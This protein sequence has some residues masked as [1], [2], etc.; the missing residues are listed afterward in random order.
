MAFCRNCGSN[1]EGLNFCENCGTPVETQPVI[2]QTQGAALNRNNRQQTMAEL[3]SLK[4]YFGQKK[5]QYWEKDIQQ[6]EIAKRTEKKYTGL[7]LPS[8]ITGL[9]GWGLFKISYGVLL[10]KLIICFGLPVGLIAAFILLTKKNKEKLKAAQ[11]RFAELEREL[12][13]HYSAFGYCPIGFE[14]THPWTLDRL[15]RIIQEGLASTLE[16]ALI[17]MKDEDHME[18]MEEQAML[19][20]LAATAAA[21]NAAVAADNSRQAKDAAWRAEKEARWSRW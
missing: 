17:R 9:L 2:Y 12:Q 18:R 13:E 6:L 15:E 16:G 11:D 7:I 8:V 5:E 4:D 1:V 3:N 14:H 20:T 10:A 19:T 21:Q